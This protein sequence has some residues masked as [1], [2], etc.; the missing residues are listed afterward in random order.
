MTGHDFKEFHY[1]SGYHHQRIT[2][3]ISIIMKPLY[4]SENL[5]LITFEMRSCNAA[6]LP[7]L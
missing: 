6:T 5:K 1:K 7:T 4:F 2:F 3:C